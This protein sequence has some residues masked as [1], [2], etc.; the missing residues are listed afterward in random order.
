MDVVNTPI[1]AEFRDSMLWVT[2]EDG[3]VIG[4]PIAW[5][6]FL[7]NATP[8]QRNNFKLEWN[9]I[10]W[11]DLDDG[12]STEGMLFGVNPRENAEIIAQQLSKQAS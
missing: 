7:D 4:T 5:Y 6:P 2:L 8:E 12:L 1:A 3:R 11:T 10:W 9:A